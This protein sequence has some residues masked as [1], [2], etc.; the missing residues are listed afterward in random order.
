MSTHDVWRW[1]RYST[2]CNNAINDRIILYHTALRSCHHVA[3]DC[4]YSVTLTLV[5]RYLMQVMHDMYTTRLR[6][7]RTCVS[8]CPGLFLLYH[9]D[10]QMC[11][12]NT[13]CMNNASSTR[14]SAVLTLVQRRRRWTNI[15]TALGDPSLGDPGVGKW[16]TSFE[17]VSQRQRLALHHVSQQSD[18]RGAVEIEML[19]Y[20]PSIQ[21]LTCC[22]WIIHRRIQTDIVRFCRYKSAIYLSKTVHLSGQI[23]SRIVCMH[24]CAGVFTIGKV[25]IFQNFPLVISVGCR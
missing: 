17:N 25:L 2:T 21:H 3:C 6:L 15:K 4:D 20:S 23:P 14:P 18:Y 1:T 19:N 7:F 8:D 24:T 10:P 5:Y 13:K 16:G 9:R 12:W 11:M 22:F